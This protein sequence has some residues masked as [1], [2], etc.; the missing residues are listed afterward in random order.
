MKK[1]I[2]LIVV[3][4]IVLIGVA[5]YLVLNHNESDSNRESNENVIENGF[6]NEDSEEETNDNHLEEESVENMII[7]VSD[8]SSN[9]TFELNNSQAARSL[10]EQLPLTIEVENF[11][12]NEKIFYPTDELDV[13]NTPRATGGGAGILAYYE[14]WGDV[15]MFYDS[16]SSASGLYELGSAIENANQIG[17]LSGEITIEKVE[18]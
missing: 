6:S 15:V 3:I 1:V 16:F 17:N 10:Y 7:R 2:G 4:I 14:P 13:D 8:R 12:S 9:I 5:G 11:S 18:N